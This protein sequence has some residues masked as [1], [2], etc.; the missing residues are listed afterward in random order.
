[1][2]LCAGVTAFAGA[3]D[4]NPPDRAPLRQDVLT[5]EKPGWRLTFRDEFE[6][7]ALDR[8]KWNLEDPWGKERNR[9]LQAYVRDACQV[10]GGFLH[11]IADK[12][13]ARYDG[14]DR[15]FVSGLMTTLDKF[16]QRYG[17]FEVRCR[18]PSGRGLWPAFWLLPQPLGWPP[19]IDVLEVKGQEPTRI[20]LTHHWLEP[21]GA[22]RYS[23]EQLAWAGPDFSA[24]FHMVAIEWAP[25]SIKWFVD[26]VERR[27]TSHI[28]PD[29]KMFLLLN[30]AVGGEFVGPPDGTTVFPS[31]FEVDYVRVYERISPAE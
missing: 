16:S 27:R 11:I 17:W 10:R 20:Y 1:V 15:E 5:A 26:G 23:W 8:T 12:R 31:A 30:L 6:G 7:V 18:V 2:L 13:R 24:D 21:E 29:T 14:M 25:G 22:F 19:E 4:A 3:Q 28:V 9:E